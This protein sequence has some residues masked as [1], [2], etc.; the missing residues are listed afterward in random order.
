M[1]RRRRRREEGKKKKT[2]STKFSQH[3][4]RSSYRSGILNRMPKAR[5]EKQGTF[6]A[7]RAKRGHSMGRA[8]AENRIESGTRRGVRTE[9]KAGAKETVSVGVILQ[10]ADRYLIIVKECRLISI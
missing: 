8:W 2:N 5:T 1:K 7:E 6:R 3:K 10:D 4:L 9:N